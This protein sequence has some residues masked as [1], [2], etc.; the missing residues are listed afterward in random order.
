[1][2]RELCPGPEIDHR[3]GDGLNNQRSNLRECTH[4][5]N[6]YNQRIPRNNTSGVKG[7]FWHNKLSKWRAY[8]SSEGTV[9][10][11]GYFQDLDDAIEARSNGEQKFHGEFARL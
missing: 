7:V 11:L 1:M 3:D 2:H 9:I 10:H 5:Q 6:L 4:S 8:I